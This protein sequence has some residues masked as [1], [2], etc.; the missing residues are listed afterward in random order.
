[1]AQ[2]TDRPALKAVELNDGDL[3]QAQG[4]F[5]PTTGADK[6]EFS[7]PDGGEPQSGFTPTSGA[8]KMEFSVSNRG[9]WLF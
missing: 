2:E 9:G 4:G 3:D 8:D 5:T 1:M 7:S 6:M